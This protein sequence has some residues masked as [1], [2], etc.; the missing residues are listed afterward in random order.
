MSRSLRLGQD[1]PADLLEPV[2]EPPVAHDGPGPDQG[3]LL[4]GPGLGQLI[5]TEPLDGGHQDACGA[6]G[7]KPHVR[8]VE[9]SGRR[10]GGEHVEHSLAEAAVKGGGVH[11][12]PAVA[13]AAGAR[14]EKH[15]VEIGIVPQL[16]PAQLAVGDD[17]K[18][19]LA[20]REGRI[21]L[22]GAVPFKQVGRRHCNDPGGAPSPR[23]RTGGR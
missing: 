9:P 14:V 11:R 18:P 12:L 3:L 8:L 23:C 20:G 6:A 19:P 5:L 2:H 16:K 7:P 13:R 21:A 4:P 10:M 1:L 22:G 15:Q 17:R